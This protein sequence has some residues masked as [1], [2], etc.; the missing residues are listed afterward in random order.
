MFTIEERTTLVGISELRTKLDEIL[1][2]AKHSKVLIG[3]RNKPVAVLM[4]ID[5]YNRLDELIE[6]WTDEQ[7]AVQATQ[8]LAGAGRRHRIS[9]AQAKKRLGL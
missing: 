6:A 2:A 8:R 7:L 5:V 3:R 9:L 1:K 4:D